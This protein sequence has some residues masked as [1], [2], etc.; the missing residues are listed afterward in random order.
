MDQDL[1]DIYY[2]VK[3]LEYGGFAPA[4]RELGIPKSTLSR[5][6]SALEERQNVQLIHRTTRQFKATEIGLIYYDRCQ[7]VLEAAQAAQAVID[8]TQTG[9]CGTIR[10][11]CPIALLHS[12]VSE[13]LVEFAEIYPDVTIQILDTNRPTELINDGLD[14]S[15]RARPFP[16]EDSGFRFRVLGE[17][18]RHL[19]ASPAFINE[20]KPVHHPTDLR[21]WPSLAN[22]IVGQKHF[23]ELNNQNGQSVSQQHMPRLVTTDIHTLKTAAHKGLGVVLMPDFLIKDEL[24]AGDLV[25]VLKDWYAE[26]DV[27]HALYPSVKGLPPSVSILLD[28]LKQRISSFSRSSL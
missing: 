26:N 13:L 2:F 12:I 15:I 5:R 16:L 10:L 7:Q 6:I 20:Q 4:G 1:N 24:Q 17:S 21:D 19:V 23:W 25:P 18:S 9:P 27:I 14:I 11:S 28:F 8:S 22:G 3:V